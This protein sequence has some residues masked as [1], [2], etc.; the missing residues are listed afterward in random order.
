AISERLVD[1]AHDAGAAVIFTYHTPTVSCAR[2]TMMLFGQHPC[3]GIV[4][5]AR[6][7]AC[8][9]AAH[10]VPKALA[11]LATV[12]PTVLAAGTRALAKDRERLSF[13]RIPGLISSGRQLFHDFIRKVDHVVAVCQ[14]VR[15][16]LE[17]NGVPP[18]KITLS[19]Q[20][21]SQAVLHSPP[22]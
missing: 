1:A 14:W 15:E 20:G 16:V 5:P 7:T 22:R 3:D 10:G 18:E 6:C 11:R 4:K 12:A 8:T 19:R 9:L 17:R 2:G 21:L 13:L